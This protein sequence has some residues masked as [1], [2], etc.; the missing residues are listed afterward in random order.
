MSTEKAIS[1][2]HNQS[3]FLSNFV[4]Q[5]KRNN[6]RKHITPIITPTLKTREAKEN[7]QRQ[8]FNHP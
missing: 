3:S 4:T 1:F 8:E 2:D 5:V 6:E 7:R